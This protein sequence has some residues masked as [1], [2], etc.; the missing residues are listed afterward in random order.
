MVNVPLN[1]IKVGLQRHGLQRFH[2]YSNDIIC[3]H[4]LEYIPDIPLYG[5]ISSRPSSSQPYHTGRKGALASLSF[6]LCTLNKSCT[7]GF[8]HRNAIVQLQLQI[9]LLYKYLKRKTKL[10]LLI[11]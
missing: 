1:N 6:Y 8:K 5:V 11:I 9:N 2:W 10:V 4:S 3:T 7:K